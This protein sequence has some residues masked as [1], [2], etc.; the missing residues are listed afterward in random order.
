MLYLLADIKQIM[1][2]QE[3]L[4]LIKKQENGTEI[5]SAVKAHVEGLLGEKFKALETSRTAQ[6]RAESLESLVESVLKLTGAEGENPEER[7]KS[8]S[9]KVST[10]TGELENNKKI[11]SDLESGKSTAETARNEIEQKLKSQSRLLQVTDAA[12][13]ANANPNV[14]RMLTSDSD[15]SFEVTSTESG[16]QVLVIAGEEKK[17]IQEFA[18]ANWVDF[19]PSLFPNDATPESFSNKTTLPS[20]SPS[21]KPEQKDF[22][23]SYIN[24]AGFGLRKSS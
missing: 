13:A 22:V 23:Q 12:I 18:L 21:G 19:I 9:V 24:S 2:Y 3:A 17:P 11:I 10:L 14:L 6:A 5:I 20:G 16:K 1:D 8:L 4:S 15:I 7:I